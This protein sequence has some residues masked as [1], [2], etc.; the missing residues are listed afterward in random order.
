M[1]KDTESTAR[2]KA[3]ISGLK[4][5]ITDANRAI[6]LANSEFKAAT[7]GLKEFGSSADGLQAKQKQ[8]T[9][10]LEQQNAKLALYAQELARTEDH[11]GANS[12]EADNLRIKMNDLRGEIKKTESEIKSTDKA[13]GNLAKGEK[14]AGEDADALAEDVDS[15]EEDVEELGKESEKTGDKLKNALAA[16]ARIAAAAL[17]AAGAAAATLF[18][19]VVKGYGEFEQ[20]LGGTEAVFGEFAGQVQ[21]SAKTAYRTLGLS[22]T[23]YM[24]SIN[25]M[26][27]LLQGAG[28]DTGR[29]YELANSS[30][31]RAADVAS[32]MGINTVDAMDAISAAAK[33]NFTMMDNLGVA[34]NATTLEAYALEKG[35]NFNWETATNAEKVELALGMFMDRTQN[36][37]GNFEREAKETITGSIGMLKASWADLLAGMGDS[38]ADLETLTSNLIESLQAVITNILPVVENVAAVL[39]D[40]LTQVVEMLPEIISPVIESFATLVPELLSSLLTAADELLPIVAETF[41]LILTELIGMA[42][43]LVS[44]VLSMLS[45][46]L[47]AL[48]DEMPTLV[49]TLVAVIPDIVVAI[50][51]ALPE[52]IQGIV[53]FLLT[54]LP[55]LAEAGIN[56][57]TGLVEELPTIIDGIIEVIPTIIEGLVG[58]FTGPALP[59]IIEAGIK[60]ITALVEALPDIILA[61]VDAIPVIIDALVEFF[62]GPAIPSLIDAGI[63]LITSLVTE[64]PTIITTIVGKIPE[65]IASIVT[66]IG[67]LWGDIAT[68]GKELFL[69]MIKKIPDILTDLKEAGKDLVMGIIEGIGTMAED[70]GQAL[71]DIAQSAITGFLDFLG[72]E[73]PSKVFAAFGKSI[74]EGLAIGISGSVGE[75]VLAAERMAQDVAEAGQ[76]ELDMGYEV[77]LSRSEGLGKG[78]GFYANGSGASYIDNSVSLYVDGWETD[79]DQEVQAAMATIFRK[80]RRYKNSGVMAYA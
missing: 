7:G 2:F 42:P 55:A 17:A 54:C 19:S 3:D 78:S 74:P 37:A 40:V 44:T 71:L 35:V 41:M 52:L 14:D 16:G 61:I 75:A 60:L 49:D 20:A 21:D 48:T 26:G 36:V 45:T 31:I 12:A 38:D 4:Q 28:I 56:L 70:V 6:K 65:I 79:V 34:M 1:A 8:L 24:N 5:G 73:S 10:T 46:L 23:E 67:E 58:F 50:V 80:A 18:V 53:E 47:T 11:Y 72:I 43:E 33:G 39:P 57:L 76:A 51:D 25:K 29:A 63:L 64:L 62:T 69:Q 68:A 22:Q 9:T 30:M 66:K 77:N 15:A 27:Q 13:L 59:D 32:V